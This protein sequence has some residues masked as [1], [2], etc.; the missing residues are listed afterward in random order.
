MK[1]SLAAG[2]VAT[3]LLTLYMADYSAGGRLTL[4]INGAVQDQNFLN[5]YIFF[6][7][8]Y[9]LSGVIEKKKPLMVLP[10]GFILFFTLMTGSRGALL[11]LAG[12]SAVIV[13]CVLLQEKRIRL[14]TFVI[15]LTIGTTIR[16][17]I[18]AHA[19][20]LIA[21]VNLRNRLETVRPTP[22]MKLAHTAGFVTFFQ[23]RP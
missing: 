4:S 12:I 17:A 15:R 20:A 22:Q 9:F 7:Y 8:I 10:V 3:V 2:G 14:S 5:G 1:K 18:I 19:P 16:P 6:A 21:F 23:Y 13:F 11:V